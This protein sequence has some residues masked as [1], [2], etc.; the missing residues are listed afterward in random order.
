MIENL[1]A[2]LVGGGIGALAAAA[3]MIRDGKVR[4]D[5][6]SILEAEPLLGGS[7]D[8]TQ[9]AGHGYS[10]RGG[11][12]LRRTR[13]DR[14]PSGTRELGS[15]CFLRDPVRL[16]RSSLRQFDRKQIADDSDL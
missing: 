10:M 9:I 2:Y 5:N 6:I 1:K 7:L 11:R 16:N 15:A 13:K 14:P 3:F 12:M 4:A 8:G